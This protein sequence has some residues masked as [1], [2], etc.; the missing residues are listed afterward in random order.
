M[1]LSNDA[2]TLARNIVAA[3]KSG[4]KIASLPLPANVAEAMAVQARVL[5]LLGDTVGGWKIMLHPQLGK[6]TAP[7]PASL[8][9]A[10][11]ATFDF[12]PGIGVEVEVAYRL[13]RDLPKG[14][15]DRKSVLAA[16]D[17]MILGIEVIRTRMASHND[18]FL[19]F[20][21]D[22]LAN[23]GYV[24]GTMRLTE[25]L[26]LAKRQCRV[27]LDDTVLFDKPCFNTQGDQLDVLVE[28]AAIQADALGGLKAGQ[29]ITTGSQ[30]GGVW[31][32]RPG[33]IRAGVDG[34]ETI[35]VRFV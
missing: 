34:L 15:Y 6:Y 22:N 4:N 10:A 11:G 16:V 35:E 20:L 30:C 28:G 7:M 18:P 24:S 19:P 26:D 25:P 5:E 2:E 27:M 9:R 12:K 17:S 23:E 29:I 3:R 32:D 13:G 8:C 14:V 1:P 33:V 21:A 31:F